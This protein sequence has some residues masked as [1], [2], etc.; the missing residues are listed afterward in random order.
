M[1]YSP[2]IDESNLRWSDSIPS[3]FTI[4]AGPGELDE[5]ISTPTSNENSIERG[6]TP[7]GLLSSHDLL[8]NGHSPFEAPLILP[9]GGMQGTLQTH[10]SDTL[11]AFSRDDSYLTDVTQTDDALV[12]EEQAPF[13]DCPPDP[14]IPPELNLKHLR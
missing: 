4:S 8:T 3:L 12:V 7:T 14:E 1:A 2:Q 11:K 10:K 9:N 5:S 13:C 6:A